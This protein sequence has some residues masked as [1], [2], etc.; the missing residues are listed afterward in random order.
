MP[1]VSGAIGEFAGTIQT[2]L[3]LTRRNRVRDHIAELADLYDKLKGD[4]RLDAAANS[5]AAAINH[6]AN[7][8]ESAHLAPQRKL[9]YGSAAWGLVLTAL[10]ICG[11]VAAWRPHVWWTLTLYI[12]GMFGT[13]V[14][15]MATVST[16][17]GED[18]LSGS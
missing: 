18:D 7:Q 5:I 1:D 17:R 2:M 14:L 13:F 12:L 16:F 6:Q 3:G 8:L 15:V 11:L 10:A 9:N 4:E